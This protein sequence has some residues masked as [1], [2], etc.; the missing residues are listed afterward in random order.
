[1]SNK[2]NLIPNCERTA[3]RRKEIATAG[4]VAS[5]AARRRK[6][7]MREW[8]EIFGAL[9]IEVNTPGGGKKKTDLDGAVIFGQY[10]SAIKKQNT[11]AAYFIAQ[12]KGELEEKVTVSSDQPLVIVRNQ[13]EKDKL[14][15][16]NELGV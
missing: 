8:A 4:G 1:M 12:L 13:E 14:D 16:L 3:E 5:G 11:K 10:Q 6:K 9:P 7:S 15:K 2:S